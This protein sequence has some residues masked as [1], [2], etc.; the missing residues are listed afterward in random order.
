[1]SMD[2]DQDDQQATVV[3]EVKGSTAEPYKVVFRKDGDNLKAL[4]GCR[5]GI[6]NQYC[7]HRFRI[8]AGDPTGIVSGNDSGVAVVAAW[9]DGSHIQDAMEDLHE[10]EDEMDVLRRE[11]NKAKSS[12]AWV[13][14]HGEPYRPDFL[15]D[16]TDP[17]PEIT[18]EGKRFYLGGR[19]EALNLDESK[20][21]VLSLEGRLQDKPNG[22]ADYLVVNPEQGISQRA[23]NEVLKVQQRGKSIPVITEVDWLEAAK[24]ELEALQ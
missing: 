24:L 13:M 16:I 9:M 15:P 23:F 18:F 17:A 21:L 1:M 8:L 10:L 12:L 3:F 11:V 6:N 5:A 19:F 22:K 2:I 20:T 14:R 7:K 4:C